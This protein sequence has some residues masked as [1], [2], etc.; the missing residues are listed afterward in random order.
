MK[1]IILFLF[2]LIIFSFSAIAQKQDVD[3]S[4]FQQHIDNSNVQILDVR[5]PDEYNSGH[6]KNAMLADW[7]N[8][9]DFKNGIKYLDKSKPVLV[10]CASGGRSG[11]AAQWL[12]DNDFKHVENLKGGFNEWKLEKKSYEAST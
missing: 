8:K 11:Q 9:S 3:P 2:S 7:T 6:I 1:N 10:Y 4:T 5:T 12:A